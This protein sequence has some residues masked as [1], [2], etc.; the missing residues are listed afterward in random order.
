MEPPSGRRLIKST[1]VAAVGAIALLVMVILPA[2]YGL[3]PLGTGQ[4]LGLKEMG[5]I[6]VQLAREAEADA[7]QQATPYA[8]AT[9]E[10][11]LDAIEA[12][13]DEIYALLAAGEVTAQ[14]TVSPETANAVESAPPQSNGWQ[15]EISITLTP[16]QGVE[17]KLVMV[18]GAEAEF[19]WTANGGTLNYDTHGNGPGNKIS[20]EKGRGVAQDS[21]M[22]VAA[23]DGDHGWF[24]RNRT[25]ADVVLTLRTRGAYAKLK[26]TA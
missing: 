20:Y 14:A 2:E 11:R 25:D 8:G 10:A 21:G 12:R 17:Y 4:L 24:F 3:D 6:K 15:D 5:E 19:E 7:E 18:S 22:L 16:G 13:L 23:F 1:A 9:D 26:R